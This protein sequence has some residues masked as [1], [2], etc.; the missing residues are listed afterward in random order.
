[1]DKQLISNG[2]G[3]CMNHVLFM[4]MQKLTKTARKERHQNYVAGPGQPIADSF[5]RS[6]AQ[7]QNGD[8]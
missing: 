7:K 6:Y 1:M 8:E 3:S 5:T 4:S 2:Q